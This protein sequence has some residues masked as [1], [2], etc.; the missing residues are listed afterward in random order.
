MSLYCFST[1]IIFAQAYEAISFPVTQ[2]GNEL[3]YPFTGGMDSPQVV[4]LDLDLDGV[5]DLLVFDRHG[6]VFIPFLFDVLTDSYK[7]APEYKAIFPGIVNFVLKADY[8][9][10]GIDDLFGHS[11][12][13]SAGFRVYEGRIENGN[14]VYEELTLNNLEGEFNNIYSQYFNVRAPLAIPITDVP[15]ILDYENDGDVDVVTFDPI[16]SN[17][18]LHLNMDVENGNPSNTFEM[19]R[20]EACWGG[21]VESGLNAN[22]ILS[23]VAGDCARDGEDR[24]AGSTLLTLD[25]ENDGDHDLLIGDLSSNNMAAVFNNKQGSE[26]WFDKID[27][28]FPSYDI[29]INLPVFA[30]SFLYDTNRDGKE[31]LLVAPNNTFNSENTDNLHL[32]TNVADEGFEFSYETNKFLVDGHLDFGS[33]S[34]PEFVD[35]NQDGLFDL[36]V[37][38][39]GRL[40][41]NSYTPKLLYYKNVGSL[42]SPAFV[43]DND[44]Y[45]NFSQFAQTGIQPS[46]GFGDLDGDDDIDLLVAFNNGRLFYYEN[47]AGPWETFNFASPIYPFMDIQAG[48]NVK[49]EIYDL[50]NDGLGDII[51]GEQNGTDIDGQLGSFTYY[52]NEGTVGEPL[53]FPDH[54]DGSNTPFL[55]DVFINENTRSSSAPIFVSSENQLYLFSGSE[56]G[57]IRQWLIPEGEEFG[58]YE[59]I[60]E[61]LGEIKEGRRTD[62]DMEDI[63]NDGF[64]EIIIG[65]PRGGLALFKTDLKSNVMVDNTV[66]LIDDEIVILP[67]PALNQLNI[68]Y[69]GTKQIE[70]ISIISMDGK[71]VQVPNDAIND[72]IDIEY[73]SSGIYYIQVIIAGESHALKFMKM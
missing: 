2:N 46:I 14:L 68:S 49:P 64:Y 6:A 36:V 55:G 44:D 24:H 60:S 5:Q 53:F 73:L 9:Q 4:S 65:G 38:T 26:D 59:L 72:T 35:V 62:I 51:I 21:I 37:S 47:L 57:G 61:D 15:A 23:E 50:N 30:A 25:F 11:A 52:Q 28:F 19:K 63:D 29:P 18:E 70:K 34:S 48:T 42:T 22:L 12:I 58:T 33:F 8:N 66:E 20:V 27:T 16:G 43:L 56:L 31:D 40:S 3:N 13:H 41:N 71:L 69:N 1:T 54:L 45:L 10:D 67:N 39:K 7:Y 17:V 32:Y